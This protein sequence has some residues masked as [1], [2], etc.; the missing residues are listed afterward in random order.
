MRATGPERPAPDYQELLLDV[1]MNGVKVAD[2]TLVLR[3]ADGSLFASSTDL[4]RWRIRAPQAGSVAHAGQSFA[5]LAGI[6]GLQSR[7]DE[8]RLRLEIEVPADALVTTVESA[9]AGLAPKPVRPGLGGFFNYNLFG[10]RFAGDTQASG[11]FEGGVFNA[12]GVGT[13]GFTASNTSTD[14]STASNALVRLDANWRH[15]DPDQL[16]TLVVGDSINRPGSWGRA[17]RFGGVQYGTNF[18]TQ[19]SLITFP[20]Q[21]VSG[22]AT[23]PSAVDVFVNNVPV[24][25][26]QVPPG[27]F[28]ITNIPPV[29][30][31]GDVQLVVRD[32]LGREQVITQPFYASTQLLREGLVDFSYELGAVRENYGL[33]SN[34][35]GSW[36]GSATYRRGLTDRLTVEGRVEGS[37]DGGAG[38]VEADW[39][40]SDLAILSAGTV[41]S[42]S[43]AGT[44]G[45]FLAG[46]E[47]HSRGFS[48]AA[49]SFW[50]TPD[51]RQVG[52]PT[53]QGPFVNQTAVSASYQAG[54]Y[55]TFGV[56][57][58]NQLFRGQ[59]A[60]EVLSGTYSVA[61]G[62]LGF[63]NF[64]ATRTLGAM[65]G[66]TL[67]ASITVPLGP[68][69]SASVTAQRSHQAGSQDFNQA[70]VSVQRN[71]P[72]GEG[73]GYRLFATNDR[74]AQASVSLQNNVGTYTVEAA[75]FDGEDAVR[76]NVTGG[77]G[78][79]GGHPFL[80][81]TLT[82]SFGLVRVADY[83][84]VRVLQDNQEVGRTDA[85]GYAVLPRLRDYDSNPVRIDLH[86]LPL[87]AKVEASRL[88][89]VPYFRTG[90]LLD[91]PVK[92]VRGALLRLVLDSGEPL[93]AGALVT[94]DGGT[95][96][97]PVAYRGDV[98]VT[99]LMA[100][101]RLRATWR[102]QSC[103]IDVR[104]P[105]TSDP[106]PDLGTY[107]CKG[108]ER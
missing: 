54:Q 49:R 106:L 15:D 48:V 8:S 68:L 104:Y 79:V 4:Q 57:Y 5:P 22:V 80:A 44:G 27:P 52:M 19:P 47:H 23:V 69:T 95:E 61:I 53:G 38:G 87:D 99:G 60:Q 55:G 10:Q 81:R 75:R 100:S 42:Q 82:D 21:A 105:E 102:G 34:D 74:N 62:R 14:G 46:I 26:R 40:V 51:F 67:F 78:L 33:A 63:F 101:S 91:F 65:P 76:A 107:P 36:V 2:S 9:A 86:D 6:T 30:G 41:A 64:S 7:L 18:T 56:A 13:V 58:A 11:L 16:T 77:I 70:S 25:Q 28:S 3:G 88:V 32:V 83:A 89:A 59:E 50:A 43:N 84:N 72:P 98:Y 103:E 108:V 66:T 37:A 73:W 20:L 29:T 31:A 12:Y 45:L 96:A 24:G 90:L 39:L 35:Y 93:P 17:V 92:R 97:F 94:V 85:D 71:L 1:V